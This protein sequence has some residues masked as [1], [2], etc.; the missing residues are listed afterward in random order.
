MPISNP[1][2]F[3]SV[4]GTDQIVGTNAGQSQTGLRVFLA[5]LNSGKFSTVNDLVLLGD[6]NFGNTVATDINLAGS[7]IVGSRAFQDTINATAGLLSNT[8]GAITVLGSNNFASYSGATPA[9][10]ASLICIG[11]GIMPHFVGA[12]GQLYNNNIFVGNSQFYNNTG[13]AFGMF[14]NIVIGTGAMG[15]PSPGSPSLQRNVFL[16]SRIAHNNQLFNGGGCDDNVCI[17]STSCGVIG[18]GFNQ[19]VVIGSQAGN[20]MS[21]GLNNVV[22]GYG[23]NLSTYTSGTVAIGEGAG[24]GFDSSYSVFIGSNQGTT[25]GSNGS[26]IIGYNAGLNYPG[27]AYTFGVE[28]YEPSTATMYSMFYGNMKTGNLCIGKLPYTQR[29]MTTGQNCVK[30][31]NG[32]IGP[33]V[34]AGG[35]YLYCNNGALHWVGTSGTETILAPA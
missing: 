19:N 20:N 2:Y 4:R 15:M 21:G 16:G 7:T 12:A 26:I 5:G 17:G 23:A 28:S 30:L 32:S 1:S 13:T 22:I 33:T 9:N 29:D 34:P 10:M 27:T 14:D 8:V 24:G 35:G 3:P 31:T 11:S 25:G 6:N 18:T